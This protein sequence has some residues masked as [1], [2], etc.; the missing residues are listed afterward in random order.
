[1]KA[2]YDLGKGLEAYLVIDNLFNTTY[3]TDPA[4][5]F[6]M[7]GRQVRFGLQTAR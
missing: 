5:P 2:V 3:R 7:P 6:P 4:Y 1:M